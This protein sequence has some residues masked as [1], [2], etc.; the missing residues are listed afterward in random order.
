[1]I[2]VCFASVFIA[3]HFFKSHIFGLIIELKK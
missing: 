3:L 1:M 2:H